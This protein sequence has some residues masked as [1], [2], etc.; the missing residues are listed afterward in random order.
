M[1]VTCRPLRCGARHSARLPGQSDRGSHPPRLVLVIH[2]PD[3]DH[4]VDRLGG[5]LG[6]QRREDEVTGLGDGERGLDRLEVTHFADEDDVRVLAHRDDPPGVLLVADEVGLGKTL[7][8][9]GVIARAIERLRELGASPRQSTP[10]ESHAF[11]REEHEK[12]G[13]IVKSANVKLE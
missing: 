4:A 6:V 12:W 3:V 2:R 7:V 1:P 13:A 10:A 11:M 5:V 8:A 9:R